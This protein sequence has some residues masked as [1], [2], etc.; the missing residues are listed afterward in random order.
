MAS[1]RERGAARAAE[2]DLAGESEIHDA[3][4]G[5]KGHGGNTAGGEVRKIRSRWPADVV[6][7]WQ[8]RLFHR[9]HSSNATTLKIGPNRGAPGDAYIESHPR[10]RRASSWRLACTRGS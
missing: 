1:D 7:Y 10:G 9:C 2:T 4:Q 6:C 8:W 5:G 3:D